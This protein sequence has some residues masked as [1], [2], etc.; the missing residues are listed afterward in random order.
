MLDF[1]HLV[2][3]L[4]DFQAYR[5][6][7]DERHAARLARALDAL[8]RCSPGWETLCADVQAEAE[9]AGSRSKPLRGLPYSAPDGCHPCGERPTP[10]TVVATDGSQI[11]PD[12][13]VEPACYLLNIARVALHYGTEEPVVL[14]AEPDLRFRQRDLDDLDPGGEDARLDVT[15]EVVS[16][17]RDELELR[18]L[19][20]T[21]YEERRPARP[22]VAMADGTLIRWMLRGMKH[23]ALEDRLVDRYLA[24]LERFREEGIPVCSYVSRPANTEVVNLLRFYLGEDDE[25]PEEDSLRGLLD[26]HVFERVLAP[27]QRSAV[28]ASGSKILERYGDAHHIGYFYVR[29]PHEVARVELPHWVTEQPG[30]VDL[31]HAVVLD[32]CEKGGGYPI[33]LTEAHERAVVRAQEKEIFYRILERQMRGAGLAVGMGSGKTF[34]KRAPRV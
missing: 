4:H 11:Y 34:S 3:Q 18:W 27:G 33:A 25:R 22:L 17:L 9:Q 24:Q 2:G 20:E 14:V 1:H 23:R 31:V 10:V 21:A 6:A 15:A 19:F 12:R 30:V 5:R 28:F 8:V 16:A 32:Q 26:R 7:E 29:L 13:H